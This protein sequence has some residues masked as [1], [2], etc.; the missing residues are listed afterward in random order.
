MLEAGASRLDITPPLPFDIQPNWRGVAATALHAPLEVRACVLRSD[1]THV[2][3]V[4][5]DLLGAP[6]DFSL[7]LRDSVSGTRSGAARNRYS[8]ISAIATQLQLPTSR[9]SWKRAREPGSFGGRTSLLRP[10]AHNV[11]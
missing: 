7:R 6:R 11:R 8:S 3:V 10:I 5:A 4:T 9:T 1:N 2:V